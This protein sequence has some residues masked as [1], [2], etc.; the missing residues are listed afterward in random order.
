MYGQTRILFA[1]GRDGLLPR[2]FAR[3]NPR[4]HTPVNNTV[5]VFAFAGDSTTTSDFAIA[6]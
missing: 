1:I 3:V 6:F 5:I 4:T 2:A